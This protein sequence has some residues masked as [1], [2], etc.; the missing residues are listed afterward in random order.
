MVEYLCIYKII[1]T[2]LN[3]H[4]AKVLCQTLN[5]R[6]YGSMYQFYSP[7]EKKTSSIWYC[8]LQLPSYGCSRLSLPP[9]VF[10]KEMV[11]RQ[12]SLVNP[13]LFLCSF[14]VFFLK[15]QTIA[16]FNLLQSYGLLFIFDCIPLAER[17][18]HIFTDMLPFSITMSKT[19]HL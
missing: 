18:L 5:F 10:M 4:F 7:E 9:N 13:L 1:I 17:I 12:F 19:A 3:L 2:I 14:G 6:K 15:E 11:Y 16:H 8:V